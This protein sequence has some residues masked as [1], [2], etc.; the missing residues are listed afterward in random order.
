[1]QNEEL[2]PIIEA[3]GGPER[4][5]AVMH[6]QPRTVY[7]WLDSSRKISPMMAK[8]IRMLAVA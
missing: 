2:R 8:L 5:A 6:V 1:M 7:R 4:F 3:W